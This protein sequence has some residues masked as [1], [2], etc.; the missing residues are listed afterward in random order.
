MFYSTMHVIVFSAWSKVKAVDTGLEGKVPPAGSMVLFYD[1]ISV[2]LT[3]D[4][5]RRLMT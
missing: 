3:S 4:V 5:K 2:H 1:L